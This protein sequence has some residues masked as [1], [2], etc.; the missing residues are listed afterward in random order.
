MHTVRGTAVDF[1]AYPHMAN[2]DVLVIDAQPETTKAQDLQRQ[3]RQR[4]LLA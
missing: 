2:I 4:V 1:D 3:F